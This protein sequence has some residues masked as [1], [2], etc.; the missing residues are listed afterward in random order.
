MTIAECKVYKRS[1]CLVLVV[2]G[3]YFGHARR[4]DSYIVYKIM[5][6]SVR[7]QNRQGRQKR[8]DS[9]DSM[10]QDLNNYICYQNIQTLEINGDGQSMWLTPQQKDIQFE[11]EQ[12]GTFMS[13]VR[14]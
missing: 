10:Q 8:R 13:L 2:S 12:S 9:I 3:T 5:N 11:E 4:T 1:I 7:G 6:A 14:H